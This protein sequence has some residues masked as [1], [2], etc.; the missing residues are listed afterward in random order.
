MKIRDSISQWM[1]KQE[2]RWQALP[3]ERQRQYTVLLF[4]A[5]VAISI[6]V[7]L[8]YWHDVSSAKKVIEFRHIENPVLHSKPP[9]TEKDTNSQTYKR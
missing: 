3:R 6:G 2:V 4:A 5:Y 1:D 8:S 9:I 7:Y